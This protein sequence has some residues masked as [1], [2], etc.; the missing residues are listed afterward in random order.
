MVDR[1]ATGD[2]VLPRAANR[3]GGSGVGRN[4]RDCVRHRWV[5]IRNEE[6]AVRSA[7][8][9]CDLK[10]RKIQPPCQ[11][12]NL[13]LDDLF[14]FNRQCVE[15]VGVGSLDDDVPR[16]GHRARARQRAPP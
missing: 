9:I 7:N 5:R 1:V 11:A 2:R 8:Q 10:R 6:L 14:G 13:W 3:D 4:H 12:G 16:V 15:V